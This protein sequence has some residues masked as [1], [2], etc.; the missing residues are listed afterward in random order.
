VNLPL[1]SIRRPVFALMLNAGLVV[2]GLVSLGRLNVDLNPDVDMPFVMVSTILPGASPETMEIEVTDLLEEEINTIEGIRTLSSTSSEGIS[3]INVEFELGYD[4]DIKA[5][6]VREKIAPLRAELPLEIEDPIVLQFDPDSAPIMSVMLGGPVSIRELSDRA[7]KD[8]SERLERLPGVGGIEIVGAREREVRI[9]LDPVRLAGYGLAID[10]VRST[11][12]QENS[13]MAGGRIEGLER[14]WTVT[15]SGKVQRVEDFGALIAAQ[16]N[17]RLIYLRDVAV[18]EDGL[19]E[20]RSL[21]RFNRERGVT[22]QV[23][24]RSGANTVAVAQAVRAEVEKVRSSL[25]P[26]MEILITQDM[27][28]FIED[29]ISSVFQD[30]VLG[31][32]LVVLVVL[33]FLRSMRSTFIASLAIPASII[34]SFTFFYLAGFTLNVMTLMALSLS[35]GVVIDDAIVVLEVIFRRIERGERR[36]AAA[37]AGASQV[38]L[39]VISTTLALCAVFVPIAFMQ[40]MVGQWF[41]EFGIVMTIAVCVSSLFALTLTPMLASRM[42]RADQGQAGWAAAIGRGLDALDRLYARVL[43]WVM[44][45]RAATLAFGGVAVLGGCGV[46]STLPLDFFATEDRGEF[47]VNMKMPVGTPLSVT[48]AVSARVEEALLEHPE[49]RNLFT[50]IGGGSRQE[51]N[52]ANIYVQ[53]SNKDDRGVPQSEI[54]A[55]VR[56]HLNTNIHEPEELMV[57]PISWVSGQ[58]DAFGTKELMYGLQGPDLDELI[59][60]SEALMAKMRADP[61]FVDVGSSFESGKP[62][63]MITVNRDVA[64]DLGV[65]ASTIGRTIRTLLAGEELGSFEERGERYE[66]RVQVLPEYR[67]TP[68]KLDSISV[69]SVSGDLVPITNVARV[70]VGEGPVSIDREN[71]ARNVIIG[72]N[73]TEGAALSVMSAKIDAWGEELGLG[74]AL[75]PSG[76]TRSMQESMLALVFAFV[77]ALLAIYMVLASLFNSLIHPFT[78]MMSAPLSFIGAFL[79]LKLSGV[80]VDMMTGIGLLV[81]MGLVMKNGILLIDYINQLRSNGTD[82]LDAI[83]EAGPARLRPVLMTAASL[84]LG[85]VPV[86]LSNSSGSEFRAGIAILTIGGMATST[87]LTLLVVPVIYDVVDRVIEASK[88]GVRRARGLLTGRGKAPATPPQT[89]DT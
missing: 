27:A 28:V 9:W 59:V 87:L 7:E 88:R 3:Q 10:D 17:G 56:S 25:P 84:I 72:A 5:Q 38:T 49:V 58:G 85:L 83:L 43:R 57:G 55:E 73:K 51:P 67:D 23:R 54:L 31:G 70:E 37:E 48:A 35:I 36:R 50:T 66:V 8:I 39:A 40:G 45:H 26:G 64:A 75:V 30:M 21:A 53:I 14:E 32:I 4:I 19:A 65:P 62:E 46:A 44:R 15:T 79:A 11:L 18:I 29:S 71:R 16:R 22:M 89:V 69:R 86:A 1:I 74:D 68:S 13:E 63:V 24:R 34:A 81:L 2:L 12:L 20:E 78:I 33:L 60:Q 6:Q 61:D 82:R 52:R 77:L 47:Q 41:Y 80:P 42:L 76:M